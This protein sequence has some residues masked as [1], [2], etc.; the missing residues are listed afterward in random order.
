M[1]LGSNEKKFIKSS[2]E[3]AI[4][5]MLCFIIDSSYQLVD[6]YWISKLGTGAPTA[7]SI[8]STIIMIIMGVNDIIGVSSISMISKQIGMGE[9]KEAGSL[10]FQSIFLKLVCAV[11]LSIIFVF[12]IFNFINLYSSDETISTM[13]KEYCSYIW[14]SFIVMFPYFSVMTSLRIIGESRKTIIISISAITLNMILNPV[15]I[16]GYGTGV[17]LGVKGAAIT[18][19]FSQSLALIVGMYFLI[20]NKK[21]IRIFDF[22][23]F[24]LNLK[25]Y[26]KYLTIGLPIGLCSILF[27]FEQSIFISILGSISKE[28]SDAYGIASRILSIV[29]VGTWGLALGA[30]VTSGQYIGKGSY[31]IIKRSLGPF[32]ML[33]TGFMVLSLSIFYLFIN[34]IMAFFSNSSD[35]IFLGSDLFK[36]MSITAVIFCG[37]CVFASP[38]EGAGKNMPVLAVHSIIYCILDIPTVLIGHHYFDISYVTMF[39]VNISSHMIGLIIMKK[40]FYSDVWV[41]ERS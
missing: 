22:K 39:L 17:A 40:I 10:I 30:S 18:T 14:P 38:F 4:P 35:V 34:H 23:S 26:Y 13:V 32:F 27:Y 36:Y 16:L 19:F 37:M 15:F 41:P 24:E 2:I 1:N 5:A 21:K 29:C 6:I 31:D 28:L 7:V 25:L 8:A 12:F 3:V 33:S 20:N 9:N 11:I